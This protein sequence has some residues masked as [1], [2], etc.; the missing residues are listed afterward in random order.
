MLLYL[1]ISEEM[2]A[3][4]MIYRQLWGKMMAV[5]HHIPA[6]NSLGILSCSPLSS[7]DY[8]G[9][10]VFYHVLLVFKELQ[11]AKNTAPS[12]K[13]FSVHTVTFWK[14]RNGLNDLLLLLLLNIANT[15]R[16]QSI[17]WVFFLFCGEF[18]Y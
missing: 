12:S 16:R 18:F 9:P 13:V 3:L 8:L 2:K 10:D 14:N 1:N 17:G 6:H 11:H 4:F 7:V 15:V 5:K